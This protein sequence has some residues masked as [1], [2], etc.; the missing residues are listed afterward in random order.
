MNM[1]KLD[2][3]LMTDQK[4][5][6]LLRDPPCA[7]VTRLTSMCHVSRDLQ[8][9]WLN[10]DMLRSQHGGAEAEVCRVRQEAAGQPISA[11]IFRDA[12]G[13]AYA[14]ALSERE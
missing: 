6:F 14:F 10:I 8:P 12:R 1:Q 9:K 7:Q 2:A 4:G 11:F 13:F 5:N 3:E